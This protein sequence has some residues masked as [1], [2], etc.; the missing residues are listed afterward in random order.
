MG[1]CGCARRGARA[2]LA[3]GARG[4]GAP[5]PPRPQVLCCGPRSG[6]DVRVPAEPLA[7]QGRR[8][9][10]EPRGR[11]GG[12][13]GIPASWELP[14]PS[15]RPSASRSCWRADVPCLPL[16]RWRP[17][18]RYSR[19]RALVGTAWARLLVSP[20]ASRQ[21]PRPCFPCASS[22]FHH[23]DVWV[24]IFICMWRKLGRAPGAAPAGAPPP[25]ACGF[26]AGLGFS[27]ARCDLD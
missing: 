7:T 21:F 2:L 9:G 18:K 27:S 23:E 16:T 12:R 17:R 5:G 25:S 4:C 10:G 14:G 20:C 13:A 22:D 11:R 26:G 1:L 24:V 6:E 19:G 3:G 15:S 8:R